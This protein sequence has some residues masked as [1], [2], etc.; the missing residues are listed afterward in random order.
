MNNQIEAVQQKLAILARE[1][2]HCR[3]W[4]ERELALVKSTLVVTLGARALRAVAG[5]SARLA[6]T[7]GQPIALGRADIA[8][9]DPSRL[10]ASAA[11]SNRKRS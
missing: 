3:W 2:D 9:N 10:P 7:R 5:P 4:L 11:R 6:D 1:I 8:A